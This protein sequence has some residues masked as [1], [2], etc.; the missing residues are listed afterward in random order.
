MTGGDMVSKQ[1]QWQRKKIYWLLC[2]S[3]C[4]LRFKK[5]IMPTVL[6]LSCKDLPE[7][8]ETLIDKIEW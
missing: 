6:K 3:F 4:N 2:D 8:K 5:E 7:K 1:N